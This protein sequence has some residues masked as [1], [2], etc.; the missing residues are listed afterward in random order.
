MLRDLHTAVEKVAT[1]ADVLQALHNG[2]LVTQVQALDEDAKQLLDSAQQIALR[3][4]FVSDKAVAAMLTKVKWLRALREAGV[5]DIHDCP[6]LRQIMHR[7]HN[8]EL[9]GEPWLQPSTLRDAQQRMHGSAADPL[10]LLPM[11]E[12]RGG[13]NRTRLEP[14]VEQIIT[15]VISLFRENKERKLLVHLIDEEVRARV[16]Q[17]EA[18]TPALRLRMPGYSTI[19]RRVHREFSSFDIHVRNHGHKAAVKRFR[20]NPIRITAERPL[21]VAEADDTDASVFLID[22][23]TGL[24]FGRAFLTSS[25]DQCTETPLGSNLSHFYRDSESAIDCILNGLYPKDVTLDE[26]AG[27]SKPWIG[28][29]H[30]GVTLLDNATY[31]HS[32]STQRVVHRL[33]QIAALAKPYAATE[34]T[35]IETFNKRVKEGLVS[36][37]AGA[38]G[39]KG[40][41]EALKRGEASAIYTVRDFKQA[42]VRWITEEHVYQP[43]GDG[44]SIRQRWQHYFAD[45]RPTV[46]WSREQIKFLRMIPREEGFR[47]SGGLLV[48]QLRYS[49]AEVE[50]LRRTLGATA[51]VTVF[52]DPHD[53]TYV[54]VQHPHTQALLHAA[55]LE[56]PRYM[57]GLT[58][59]QQKLI[60]SMCR[61]MKRRNPD[62][63][64]LIA[65]R[66]KLYELTEQQRLSNKL[67]IR[68][69]GHVNHV[70]PV[71]PHSNSESDADVALTKRC[72]KEAAQEVF[73]TDLEYSIAQLDLAAIEAE[74]SWTV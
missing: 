43:R 5:T 26:F 56:D 6:L 70:H 65:G 47:E 64:D 38:K 55:C 23:V 35:V 63:V 62:I 13:G 3:G 18:G 41:T 19:H 28:Y 71:P 44:R 54:L 20:E 1:E 53:L 8:S 50:A 33:S 10:V 4:R 49:G 52:V 48:N 72:K 68:Q 27:L 74:D 22:H 14:S 15:D 69:R 67:R 16:L 24:P 73:V 36:R 61:E 60:M 17:A 66:A 34:K 12:A 29:G 42:H 46:R 30:P 2:E 51:K 58:L 25:V 11:F 31:N 7:L 9:K 40:D 37:L 45:H 39:E 21:E 57:E 32:Q 59:R